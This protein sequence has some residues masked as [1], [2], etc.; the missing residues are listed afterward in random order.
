VELA[1]YWQV[2]SAFHQPLE[3]P[4]CVLFMVAVNFSSLIPAAPGGLG[5][6]EA[7]AT[8]VLVSVGLEH[9]K[10]LTMVLTQH[11]LQYL[12]VGIPGIFFLSTWRKSVRDSV[13]AVEAESEGAT[14]EPGTL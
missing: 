9:E 6:I 4:K 14:A 2:S 1:V 13:Q 5:V 12:V 8:A 3:L 7:A 11:V 10:A